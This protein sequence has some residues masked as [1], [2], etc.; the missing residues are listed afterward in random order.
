MAAWE[1]I[2]PR[3]RPGDH[4][5]LRWF[6]NFSIWVIGLVL[7]HATL[8]LLGVGVATLGTKHSVGLLNILHVPHALGWA[9]TL[10]ALDFVKYAEHLGMHRVPLL[11]RLHRM[12]HTDVD[13]D[14]TVGFRFHPIE[15]V[16]ST[17][18]TL[19]VIVLLGAPASAVA[20]WHAAML[21]NAAFAHGNVRMPGALDRVIRLVT[22]TP[23]MHRVHHSTDARENGRNLGSLLPWWD[24]LLG[25]YVAAPAG[26]LDAMQIGLDEFRARKHLT[27]PWMLAHPFLE[28]E[29][30][31]PGNREPL[32]AAQPL[33]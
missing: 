15:T 12:H 2:S 13:F 4:L 1:W 23:D 32:P 10:L 29:Q 33:V 7:V 9:A 24:R 16:F 18:W 3:R 28:P 22:V 25:T 11:W 30:R 17:C 19:G 5:R 6:G 27:L 14:V 20:A 31:T 26:F 21:V 8:A